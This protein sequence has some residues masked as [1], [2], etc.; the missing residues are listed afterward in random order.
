M[1]SAPSA[2]WSE[3]RRYESGWWPA[4]WGR[5]RWLARGL[6]RE[7][8]LGEGEADGWPGPVVWCIGAAE[9]RAPELRAVGGETLELE[10]REL[11]GEAWPGDVVKHDGVWVL[12]VGL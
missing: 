7:G 4:W 5:A 11:G 12:P 3:R 1:P 8:R 10:V 2:Q 6:L 9:T